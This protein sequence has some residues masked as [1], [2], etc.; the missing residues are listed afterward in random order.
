MQ[1]PPGAD[2]A[3]VLEA[4]GMTSDQEDTLLKVSPCLPITLWITPFG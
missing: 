1:V 2:A 4:I 3:A